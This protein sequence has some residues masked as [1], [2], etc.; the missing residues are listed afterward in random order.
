MNEEI[1]KICKGLRDFAQS[2][3]QDAARK[4]KDILPKPESMSIPD[5]RS[6]PQSHV[7]NPERPW[8][9]LGGSALIVGVLGAIFSHGAWAYVVG[10][11]GVASILYGKTQKKPQD[12]TTV[13][14]ARQS[15]SEPK[16]YEVA[17]KVIET[18]KMVEDKWRAKVEEC[19]GMVQRVIEA[20]SASV[21]TKG[22]LIGQTY[23]TER[24]SID[25]DAIISRLDSQPASSYPSI[26][27]EYE[28]M[29]NTCID[30]AAAEQIAIYQN[31]SQ[32]L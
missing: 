5:M 10:G 27:S 16:G 2:L 23:T 7:S 18:S 12:R 6:N 22:S 3:K 24:I 20:S 26:L 25:F 30:K 17:E 11:A 1:N 13:S 29:V 28:R 15:I 19:K 4:I 9:V 14:T 21:D 32:K 8:V 31:I